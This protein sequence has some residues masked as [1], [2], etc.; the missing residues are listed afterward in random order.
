MNEEQFQAFL[1]DMSG[2]NPDMAINAIQQFQ[3]AMYPEYLNLL[4]SSI[5]QYSNKKN[6]QAAI[7]LLYHEIKSSQALSTPEIA[8]MVLQNFTSIITKVLNDENILDNFKMMAATILAYLH[9][10]IYQENRNVLI[11]E[12][13]LTTYSQSPQIRRYLLHCTFEISVLDPNM[14]GFSIE[15]LMT[16]MLSDLNDLSLYLPRIHLFFAVAINFPELEHLHQLFPDLLSKC[17]PNYIFDLLKALSDFAERNAYFFKPHLD[18]LVM[19]LCEIALNS[20]ADEQLRNIAIIS[21]G[22]IAKGGPDMC[23]SSKLYYQSVFNILFNVATE[24]TD[25]D[26]WE[27]D[28]N[29]IS[30]YQIAI[31]T[32]GVI[33]HAI[34]NSKLVI[35]F[36]EI[37]FLKLA[38][39]NITWKEAYV[40]LSATSEVD[41]IG[42]S[43][44][45]ES[46]DLSNQFFEIISKFLTISSHPRVRIADYN[47]IKNLSARTLIQGKYSNDIFTK[48]QDLIIHES[49]PIAK[50]EAY[51]TMV[52]LFS[53]ITCYKFKPA[54]SFERLFPFLLK[55]LETQ[56]EEYYVY[57][58][59][60]LGR[61]WNFFHASSEMYFETI[62][63]YTKSL[64]AHNDLN[65]QVEA[66][67]CFSYAVTFQKHTRNLISIS[68]EY[69]RHASLLLG[70]PITEE[71]EEDLY[72][73]IYKLIIFV[74]QEISPY[75]RDILPK[76][77][78][79]AQKPV[80]IEI[81][82]V[83][84]NV[85]TMGSVYISIP[86]QNNASKIF[87]LKSDVS[88]VTHAL[89]VIDALIYA[90]PNSVEYIPQV[91]E[92][93][94]SWFLSKYSIEPIKNSC[95]SILKTVYNVNELNLN[96]KYIISCS[97]IDW[98]IKTIQLKGSFSFLQQFVFILTRSIKQAISL[99]WK[100][101]QDF[102]EILNSLNFISEY[103]IKWK[104][105]RVQKMVEY[106][107]VDLSSL[108]ISQADSLLQ[109]ISNLLKNCFKYNPD[110]TGQFYSQ[111]FAGKVNDFLSNSLSYIFGI[112]LVTSFIIGTRAYDKVI[113]FIS[114]L[115]QQTTKIGELDEDSIVSSFQS[116][117]KIFKNF[118]ISKF[119]TKIVYEYID[120]FVDYFDSSQMEQESDEIDNISDSANIALVR[121]LQSNSDF[122][123]SKIMTEAFL[124]CSPLWNAC[125]GCDEFFRFLGYLL[126]K[127]YIYESCQSDWPEFILGRIISGYQT[128]Y[129]EETRFFFITKAFFTRLEIPGEKE[130]IQ[131]TLNHLNRERN[132]IFRRILEQPEDFSNLKKEYQR[133]MEKK[134]EKRLQMEQ[135]DNQY[136]QNI[137]SA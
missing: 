99:G 105:Q 31:D 55:E 22:S 13:I 115:M 73:S 46:Q 56:P 116:M 25:D 120:F 117:G 100:N 48:L 21:L 69:Y 126:E 63:K 98:Y 78:Q 9:V 35:P 122:I 64:L 127:G 29:N 45:S 102:S 82:D 14:G 96:L 112:T 74:K 131:R 49:I 93:I 114:F 40:I 36:Y 88:D 26:P 134:R 85:Q 28:A 57:I 89:K 17:P 3:Q 91:I 6:P 97:V 108:D 107:N 75:V 27:Y 16:L 47:V 103:S 135:M 38:D 50:K 104:M 110:L 62:L 94:Q 67:H 53:Q 81:Q 33:F 37:Y 72:E 68:L 87:A 2:P 86:S 51:S 7:T 19:K 80:S 119:D 129:D 54:Q 32:F 111:I 90:D 41:A 132:E 130:N 20:N 76:L 83:F 109:G 92:I 42:L 58:L 95:I 4:I 106:D 137:Y 71:A 121:L 5:A 43:F 59:K 128:Q 30:T 60:C 77:L 118:I 79:D 12:F 23:L 70:A 11:P 1:T 15:D 101:I 34:Q 39:P 8:H 123:D 52:A 66:I 84:A 133:K 44:L 124:E 10:Y 65:I 125:P 61:L 136:F 113:Q 18:P 24:I